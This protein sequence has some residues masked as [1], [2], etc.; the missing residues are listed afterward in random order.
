MCCTAGL[1]AGMFGVGGGIIIAPLM[2]EMN[3][4]PPVAAASMAV[5]ILYTAAAAVV[6]FYTFGLIPPGYGLFFFV[7]G[8]LCTC[9][10]QTLVKRQLAKHKK[11]SLIVLSIGAVVLLSA[12]M[13]AYQ[14]IDTFV[15][16]PSLAF[17]GS[18]LCGGI[19]GA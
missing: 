8:A 12:I 3:V 6:G 18:P 5:M 9:V 15:R 4:A 14:A 16:D 19:S 7:W 2:L 17:K 1:F 10:G 13:M 11:E